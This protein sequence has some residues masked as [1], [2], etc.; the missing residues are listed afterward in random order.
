HNEKEKLNT[1]DKFL[2][3][4]ISDRSD[5]CNYDTAKHCKHITS[6]CYGTTTPSCDGM[7]ETTRDT[8]EVA[9]VVDPPK[10]HGLEEF[11]KN[12]LPQF[13][14]EIDP[15][16][17]FYGS[18]KNKR[19]YEF[20]RLYQ[21][22]A[23][24]I[25]EYMTR[26]EYLSHL[27]TQP[28]F[29]EF[30]EGLKYALKSVIIPIAILEFPKLVEKVKVVECLEHNIRVVKTQGVGSSRSNKGH[31]QRKLYNRIIRIITVSWGI[32]FFES[33]CNI[34]I[35]KSR[36][37]VF[38]MWWAILCFI[39][40]YLS[41]VCFKYKRTRHVRKDC[42]VLTK[43]KS[44]ISFV[45]VYKT[46]LY[47]KSFSHEW[48]RLGLSTYLLSFDLLVSLLITAPITISM[49]CQR[50]S[51]IVNGCCYKEKIYLV[52]WIYHHQPSL[53]CLR[54]RILTSN[55]DVDSM[56]IVKNFPKFFPKESRLVLTTLYRMVPTKL[57]SKE[58]YYKAKCFPLGG[59]LLLSAKKKDGESRLCVD[60]H[61]LYKLKIKNK[62]SLPMIDDL[63]DQLR[64]ATIF[65]NINLRSGYHHIRVRDR[66]IQKTA[67]K[68]CYGHYKYVVMSFGL[69]RSPTV[70]IYYMNKF[71][72]PFL[73]KFVVVFIDCMLVYLR[74]HEE[75]EKYLRVVLEVEFWLE[76]V[77]FLGHVISTK[78]I[79]VDSTKVDIVLQWE[80][81]KIAMKIRSFVGFARYYRRILEDSNVVDSTYKERLT[82]CMEGS[83]GGLTTSLVL[84]LPD[85]SK[86]RFTMM[87]HIK[88]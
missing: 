84:V 47:W 78:E 69:A 9:R 67:F 79:V 28:T 42:Q 22:K 76:E 6:S 27:Y 61:Q 15:N 55:Y 88:D 18:P 64:G 5:G 63:M 11:R 36:N 60:Y 32:N 77:N 2:I 85:S 70:F 54:R 16:K 72:H 51:F 52:F 8:I 14:G 34:S 1:I 65:S 41:V 50:Y 74:T 46:Y 7:L 45:K 13:I 56:V 26:F 21:G 62:Y 71:F 59:V 87:L 35:E 66:D 81:P 80:C 43:S 19:E 53:G 48:N 39:V 82:I 4:N 40:L 24:T 86:S 10:F 38:Q 25:A 31:Q 17:Y 73:D 83:I 75:H 37:K 20:L 23:S 58:G 57:D 12:D 29:E 44:M 3:N 49:M 33:P 30:E 68:T